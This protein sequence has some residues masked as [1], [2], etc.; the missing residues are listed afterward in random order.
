MGWLTEQTSKFGPELEGRLI[1]A[2]E[3]AGLYTQIVEMCGPFGVRRFLL[4]FAVKGQR[5]ELSE[6][7]TVP[8]HHGGGAP[9]GL[10]RDNIEALKRSLKVLWSDMSA[11]ASWE[12]GLLSVVRDCDNQLQVIPF[13]D[14]DADAIT[15]EQV[16]IPQQGHP[17]EDRAY[18]HL[19]ASLQAQLSPVVQNTQSIS[20]DWQEWAIDGDMLTLIYADEYE[21]SAERKRC[22]VLATF[23]QHGTWTWQVAE[24]L[25][26]EEVFCWEFFL[27]DWPAA[28][29]LGMVCVARLNGTWLFQ[30]LVSEDPQVTLL[31]VVWD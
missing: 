14:E 10:D 31:A 22:K 23:D 19:K 6:V 29:E 20:Q 30:S 12:R 24:P 16:P 11:W 5:V 4:R 2:L 7:E 26:S 28:I 17:L 25:F 21:Q 3:Q 18:V 1:A 27:C 13:F 9:K 8:L 15:L